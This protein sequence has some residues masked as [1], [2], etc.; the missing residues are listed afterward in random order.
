MRYCQL[1]ADS[2]GCKS[3]HGGRSER[4]QQKVDI[5]GSRLLLES[6]VSELSAQVRW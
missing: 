6:A 3:V 1:G 4:C 2:C 5:T